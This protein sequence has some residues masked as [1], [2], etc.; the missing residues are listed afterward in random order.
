MI[1]DIPS[2]GVLTSGREQGRSLPRATGPDIPSSGVLTSGRKRGRSLP[3]VAG[4]GIPCWLRPWCRRGFARCRWLPQRSLR[5][6]PPHL[7]TL[8]KQ[9]LNLNLINLCDSEYIQWFQAQKWVLIKKDPKIA[10]WIRVI[11]LIMFTIVYITTTQISRV[12]TAEVVTVVIF[13]VHFLRAVQA[14]TSQKIV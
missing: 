7:W 3:R 2:F 9:S 4:P 12:R 11:H 1:P 10:W 14:H 13:R 6:M 5:C 8:S